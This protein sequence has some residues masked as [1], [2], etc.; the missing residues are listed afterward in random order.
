MKKSFSSIY[1]VWRAGKGAPRHVVGVIERKKDTDSFSFK[2]RITPEEAASIGFIPYTAFS[3]LSKIYE[4]NV[5]DVFGLRLTRSERDDI[6]KYYDFW[7]I[8]PEYKNDKWYLLARTQGLRATDNFEFLADYNP[9]KD[10]LFIS[11]ICGLSYYRGSPEAIAVGDV[12]RWESE[13]RNQYDS[14]AV[15]VFKDD[16]FLG[17]V[18]RVHSEVFYKEGGESLQIQVKSISKNGKLNRVFIKIYMPG[19]CLNNNRKAAASVSCALR[20][21]LPLLKWLKEP[22]SAKLLYP[23]SNAVSSIENFANELCEFSRLSEKQ[24]V[25]VDPLILKR[26]L[27][28]F[29]MMVHT[30]K[31]LMCGINEITASAVLN[32]IYELIHNVGREFSF[33]ITRRCVNASIIQRFVAACDEIK[34]TYK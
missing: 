25:T 21:I 23:E 26:S 32:D 14:R 27:G 22:E 15:K 29:V 4:G 8:E 2:Y 18:K 34:N 12:L 33:D 20:K 11:E 16:T 10:L 3:D 28:I 7:E 19:Q 13:P 5:L 9:T 31:N 6:Q 17:Y 24:N 30:P 1:L